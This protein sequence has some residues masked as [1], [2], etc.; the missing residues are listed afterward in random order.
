MHTSRVR[1][2]GDHMIIC[3]NFISDNILMD[4]TT[5]GHILFSRRLS[6]PDLAPRVRDGARWKR[7]S[8]VL[9]V[10]IWRRP[11]KI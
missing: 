8:R 5:R 1:A 2:C 11:K 7:C 3:E 6:R 9:V 10:D 4:K